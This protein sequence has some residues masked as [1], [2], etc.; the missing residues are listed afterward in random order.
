MSLLFLL[1]L[2]QW[3]TTSEAYKIGDCGIVYEKT[4]PL[5]GDG[6]DAE[7]NQFP[8]HVAIYKLGKNSA[9]EYICGGSIIDSEIIITAAHCIFNETAQD[10]DYSPMMVVTGKYNGSW[11]IHDDQGRGQ[12]LEVIKKNV[13]PSYRGLQSLYDQDIALL[14][15]NDSI[16]FSD[17]VM[18]ICIEWDFMNMPTDGELGVFVGWGYDSNN[19]LSKVLQVTRVQPVN[20]IDCRKRMEKGTT[21]YI[22][23]DKFCVKTP[24]DEST[25]ERGDSGG[26]SVFKRSFGTGEEAKEKY[27]LYGILSSARDATNHSYIFTNISSHV[28][29]INSTKLQL[30]DESKTR[31]VCGIRTPINYTMPG[32]FVRSYT[33]YPW[34]ATIYMK[35]NGKFF[36]IRCVGTIIHQR[37]IITSTWCIKDT[38]PHYKGVEFRVITG[39]HELYMNKKE[40][41]DGHLDHTITKYH[42]Q[43][44]YVDWNSRTEN[45]MVILIIEPGINFTTA[46]VPIC[47]DWVR[48]F[49]ITEKVG[50]IASWDIDEC[51]CQVVANYTYL[52]ITDCAEAFQD[53]EEYQTYVTSEKV[54]GRYHNGTR[55]LYGSDIG[56]GFFFYKNG[57]TK[58]YLQG[59]VSRGRP[60][61][62]D[63]LIFTNVELNL[64]W[65]SDIVL[66]IYNPGSWY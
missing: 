31:R 33:N 19:V 3:A 37:A 49:Q 51:H 34:L 27:Y 48:R 10:I 64:R 62:Q 54:C 46:V 8:W 11:D 59:I 47:M 52:N 7:H 28:P 60:T 30:I 23:G 15:L 20:Y 42:R 2:F 44:N 5:V 41:E 35:K 50:M 9:Y 25:L 39:K 32:G 13:R 58:H 43:Q 29:W 40:K 26:G 16:I 38:R 57:T 53:E 6:T 4:H 24:D 56:A 55:F 63:F 1:V 65:I 22:M 18:P 21:F 45:D 66:S 12:R 17:I 14:A 61:D 36:G